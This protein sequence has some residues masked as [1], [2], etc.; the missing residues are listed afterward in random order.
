MN[1]IASLKYLLNKDTKDIAKEIFLVINTYMYVQLQRISCLIT[2]NNP[3][4][5]QMTNPCF[6]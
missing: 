3:S 5:N 1:N 4:T 2:T 6:L